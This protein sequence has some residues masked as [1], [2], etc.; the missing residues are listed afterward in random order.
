M[1]DVEK[2]KEVS[3]T[4]DMLRGRLASAPSLQNVCLRFFKAL[5]SYV[6]VWKS[7]P[8]D[9]ELESSNTCLTVM[10]VRVHKK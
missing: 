4:G 9:R 2:I 10:V 7:I 1:E 3:T 8:D 6:A 5:I